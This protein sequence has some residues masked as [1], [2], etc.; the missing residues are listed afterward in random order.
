[1]NTRIEDK[2][3]ATST[4]LAVKFGDF[5]LTPLRCLFHGH[6]ITICT[7]NNQ[8]DVAHENEYA[9]QVDPHWN[10]PKRNYL[11]I[12]LSIVFLLPGLLLGSFFKGIG[13]LLSSS[14]REKHQLVIQHYTPGD[15]IV[16]DDNDRLTLQEIRTELLKFYDPLH[17]PIHSLI[18]YAKPG[19]EIKEDV[20]IRSLKPQKL[21]L[22]DAQLIHGPSASLD[23]CLDEN[24]DASW[25]SPINKNQAAQLIGGSY[26]QQWKMDSVEDAQQD[27]PPKRSFFSSE[28][29]KRIYVV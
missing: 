25:K 23:G 12:A 20:G 29:Y 26:A 2:R 15:C 21:I 8:T 22:V 16:G 19:T 13:Y 28:R 17:R 4:S 6:K 27:I 10:K 9:T 1:M 18:I 24:L 5:C 14:I 7:K 3:P 11:R